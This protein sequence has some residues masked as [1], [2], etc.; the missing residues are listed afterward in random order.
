MR[1]RREPMTFSSSPTN[2]G[3]GS[4]RP[5]RAGQPNGCFDQKRALGAAISPNWSKHNRIKL[6][7]EL[8]GVTQAYKAPECFIPSKS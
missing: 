2:D 6:R 4:K 8:G 7:R 3:F 5:F 1:L